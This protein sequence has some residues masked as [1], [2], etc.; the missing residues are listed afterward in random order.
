MAAPASRKPWILALLISLFK[1]VLLAM[2]DASGFV[3]G[4]WERIFPVVR[5]SACKA[6]S[7]SEEFGFEIGPVLQ[8]AH[9]VWGRLYEGHVVRQAPSYYQM[10]V[11]ERFEVD[12]GKQGQIDFLGVG[13]GAEA[14]E[15]FAQQYPVKMCDATCGTL[16]GPHFLIA[17]IGLTSATLK[18]KFKDNARSLKLLQGFVS[19]LNATGIG[20]VKC[21]VYDGADAED[22]AESEEGKQFMDEGGILMNIPYLTAET[23]LAKLDEPAKLREEIAKQREEIGK[24]RED[25]QL[26]G[27]TTCHA[28]IV[29][30]ILSCSIYSFNCLEPTEKLGLCAKSLNVVCIVFSCLSPWYTHTLIYHVYTYRHGRRQARSATYS[31][32]IHCFLIREWCIPLLLRPFPVARHYRCA[33]DPSL[34]GATT[35]QGSLVLRLVPELI[36]ARSVF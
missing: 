17:E 6:T 23:V 1:L 2:P 4:M 33:A 34:L 30:R 14:W 13:T 28:W 15:A 10:V 32:P 12:M 9:K 26:S 31:T 19:S 36:Q 27:A 8:E 18:K 11:G 24:L 5:H 35:V 3:P 25:L 7:Q 16:Q 21:L 20:A 29:W 22:F